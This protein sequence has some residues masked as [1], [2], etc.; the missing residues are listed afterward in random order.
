[1][2]ILYKGAMCQFPREEDIIATGDQ[3]WRDIVKAN[4]MEPEK[5][6]RVT[7]KDEN[8]Y[9]DFGSWSNFVVITNESK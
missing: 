1:M 6:F 9:I 7:R 3:N 4:G 2:I 8:E 5:F